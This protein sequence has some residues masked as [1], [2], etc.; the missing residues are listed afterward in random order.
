MITLASAQKTENDNL[1]NS[2]AQPFTSTQIYNESNTHSDVQKSIDNDKL[3]N[4]HKEG[5]DWNQ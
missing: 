2:S 5:N 4:G 1:I 3:E